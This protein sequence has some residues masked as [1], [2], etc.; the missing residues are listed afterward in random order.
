MPGTHPDGWTT[1]EV[2]AADGGACGYSRTSSDQSGHSWIVLDLSN[3]RCG[4]GYME[5]TFVH[6]FGHDLGLYHVEGNLQ[7]H[8][9]DGEFLAGVHGARAVSRAARLRR[10][11]RARPTAGDPKGPDC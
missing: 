8:V 11:A 1:I 2:G 9:G 6:E 10:S 7:R 3:Q 5:G 4:D